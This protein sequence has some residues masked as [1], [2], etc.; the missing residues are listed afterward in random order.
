VLRVADANMAD[1]VR[2]I[3]IRRGYD[4]RDFALVV[5]GGAGPLHGAALARELSI[6]TVLVPPNPGITSA[7]GCLLVDIRHDL[8][9]MYLTRTS[10][11]VP[12]ELE[13]EFKKLEAEGRERLANEGVPEEQMSLQRKIAMRY[14]GQWRSLAVP[15]DRPLASLEA[16]EARFHAEHEREY[17]YRRDGAPVEIYQLQ[18][19]AVGVTPKP[20]FARHA[21]DG[22]APAAGGQRKVYFDEVGG[23]IDAAVYR[24]E[25]LPAGT[26]ITGPAVIDQLDSTTLV[27][28]D[29]VAEVDE[30][31]NIRMH[32]GG[33]TQ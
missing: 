4:P 33:A 16:A 12:G 8:A 13:A 32:I 30:W 11:A 23:R 22:R 20:Q 2:L 19:S 3:S 15:V 21:P 18:V 28:P 25:E 17:S 24:R 27:P 10:T 29:V 5:F 31:L 7:L 9:E 26:R 6:P 14:L 1:A